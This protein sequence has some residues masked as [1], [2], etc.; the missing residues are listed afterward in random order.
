MASGGLRRRHRQDEDDGSSQSSKPRISFESFDLYQKVRDEEKVQSTSGGTVSL[1][2]VVVCLI[3]LAAELY[4]YLVPSQREHVAVD[5]IMEDRLRINFDITFHALPCAE[6]NIDAM[7]VAGEQQNGLEHNI[8]K[9]RLAPSGQPIG[10]AFAHKIEEERAAAAEPAPSSLPPN[11]CGTCYGADTRPG[12]CCNTCDEVRAAY[13]EKGWDVGSVTGTAE[14]CAREHRNVPAVESKP[15]EG[16][17]LTGFLSVN[18]V[19]G[20]FHIAI[21]ETHARGAGHIHQFN[22]ANLGKFNVTHTIHSLSFGEIYPGM[23]NPLDGTFK[24]VREGSGVFMYYLKVVPTVYDTTGAISDAFSL[25]AGQSGGSSSSTASSAGAAVAKAAVAATHT[26]K[27]NQF[28]V[29]SQFRPA[30]S[31]GQRLN[32]I[33]GIFFVY[34]ISPFMVTVTKHSSSLAQLLT[35]TFAILGGV[36]TLAKAVDAALH[37]VLAHT[38]KG[39]SGSGGALASMLASLT[40]GGSGSGGGAGGRGGASGGLGGGR[41]G[42]SGGGFDLQAF[43]S[44]SGAGSN[45]AAAVRPGVGLGGPAPGPGPMAAGSVGLG[46]APPFTNSVSTGVARSPTAYAGAVPGGPGAAPF[47]GSSYGAPVAAGA[48][49]SGVAAGQFGGAAAYGVPV[50]AG[51][52]PAAPGSWGGSGPAAQPMGMGMGMGTHAQSPASAAAYAHQVAADKLM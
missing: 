15:G 21:G 38:G 20:N 31:V 9:M 49:A 1:I 41:G 12:Q 34:E 23:R 45:A 51:P 32:V 27:T 40:G 19:A 18:K 16:C 10:S 28:S 5:P 37:F 25:Q 8:M 47:V 42:A 52:G 30:F 6:A 50:G 24:V 39:G 3:L 33:P 14:Q 22:P 44:G 11:Y 17:R 13:A 36:L 4:S 26:I 29:T 48:D 7:D 43:L 35:S 2:A 46:P